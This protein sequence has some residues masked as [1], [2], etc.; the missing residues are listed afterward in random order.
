MLYPH[1]TRN[2]A[3]TYLHK[4]ISY[5]QILLSRQGFRDSELCP[6][7]KLLPIFDDFL[8]SFSNTRL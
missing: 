6:D 3:M 8:E 2:H 4:M 1:L 7:E 5:S